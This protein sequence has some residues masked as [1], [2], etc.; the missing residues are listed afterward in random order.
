MLKTADFN[1]SSSISGS[2]GTF[3][4]SGSGS[5]SGTGSGSGKGSVLAT[6]SSFG[7]STTTYFNNEALKFV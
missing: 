1:Y 7:G 5:G 2:S 6:G 3:S 4:G